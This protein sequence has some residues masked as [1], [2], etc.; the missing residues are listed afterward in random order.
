MPPAARARASRCIDPDLPRHPA[1]WRIHPGSWTTSSVSDPPPRDALVDTA[2]HPFEELRRV[3]ADRLVDAH[4]L[5]SRDGPVLPGLST[6]GE[7][8]DERHQAVHHADPATLHRLLSLVLV[9]EI[10]ELGTDR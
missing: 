8:D 4:D 10:L 9:P 3:P 5:C 7:V 6:V 2:Q 1:Y